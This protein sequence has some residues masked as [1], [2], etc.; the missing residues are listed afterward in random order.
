VRVVNRLL[1]AV[2]AILLVAAAF[3]VVTEIVVAQVFKRDPWI[4]P[5]DE[6]LESA[7][8]NSWADSDAVLQVAVALLLAG[9][10][11][12]VLQLARRRPTSLPL[13][14]GDRSEVQVHRRSLEGSLARAAER[15]DAVDKASVD[16]GADR[17]QV[18]ATTHRRQAPNLEAEITQSLLEALGRAHP[19]REPDIRVKV[20]RRK[21][22]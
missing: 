9:A 16:V 10:V 17:V 1:A 19:V 20:S 4:V 8:Q 3:V 7:R 18:R 11:L 5:Y 21:S 6:W 13:E 22:S 2:V 12:L 14:V 15:L